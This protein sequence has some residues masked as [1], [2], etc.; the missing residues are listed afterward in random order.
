M[1]NRLSKLIGTSPMTYN[2]GGGGKS[3]G[4]QTYTPPPINT[5]SS[6]GNQLDAQATT[7]EEDTGK[8]KAV[9][10][11]KLG[12]RGLQIPLAAATSTTA[13]PSGGVQV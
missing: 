7:F 6:V 12:T 13:T 5:T 1:M 3:G 11:A 9:D 2:G 8:E 10:K 4:G